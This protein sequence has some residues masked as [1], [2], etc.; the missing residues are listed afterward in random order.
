MLNDSQAKVLLTQPQLLAE[1]SVDGQRVVCIDSDWDLISRES[2][3]T[4]PIPSQSDNLAYTIYTSGSTGQPKGVQISHRAV[5]NFLTS[6]QQAPG[7]TASDTLLSVTTLSFDIAALEWYLP[8]ISGARLVLVSRK[9]S[10]DG[11]ALASVI[12]D[13]NVTMMQATPATWRLLLEAQWQGSDSLKILCG[14]EALTGELA[15]SL[16]ERCGALWNMYGPT[17]TTIWSL[18]QQVK[19][20]ERGVIEIGRPIANTQV[21]ILN[22][23]AQP[24]PWGVPGELCIGGAGLAR[25]YLHRPD[26]TAH[27]FVP[28]PFG[29]KGERLYRTGDL[30]RYL[31]DG[32]V[33]FLGR[34]DHQ[35]KLRGYRIELGEIESAL[36]QHPSVREAAVFT[37]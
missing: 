23:H 6:M 30:A 11:A 29:T 9:T 25:G 37:R 22:A 17:E 15:A 8:L 32:R 26:L 16:L 36:A 18:V 34:L 1:L 4:P 20:V 28:D 21:Y 33:E 5:V 24:T 2:K 7:I 12:K 19:N 27:K 3:T 13:S 31:P 35:V 14:G 10:V